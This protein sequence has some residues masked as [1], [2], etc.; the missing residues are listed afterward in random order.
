MPVAQTCYVYEPLRWRYKQL[1]YKSTPY[2]VGRSTSLCWW[3]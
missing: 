3:Y 1:V 2:T